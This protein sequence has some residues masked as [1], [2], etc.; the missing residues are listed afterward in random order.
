[1]NKA[2]LPVIDSSHIYKPK[3]LQNLSPLRLSQNENKKLPSLSRKATPLEELIKS[4]DKQNRFPSPES[5]KIREILGITCTHKGILM[6][7]SY[8]PQ[9]QRDRFSESPKRYEELAVIWNAK[10]RYKDYKTALV[11][12]VP[13]DALTKKRLKQFPKE[14]QKIFT[15][16]HTGNTVKMNKLTPTI[17]SVQKV[18]IRSKRRLKTVIHSS[19]TKKENPSPQRYSRLDHSKRDNSYKPVQKLNENSHWEADSELL[20]GW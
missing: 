2:A 1:M 11:D 13:N 3:R 18:Q 9:I 8:N 12:N 17:K 5:Y 19:N 7:N 4:I 16:A 10:K 6:I 14:T 15:S 20:T